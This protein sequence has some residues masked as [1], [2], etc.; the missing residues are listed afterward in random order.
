MKRTKGTA[1]GSSFFV[2]GCFCF[3]EGRYKER[4]A[5]VVFL[6]HCSVPCAL[7]LECG[8]VMGQACSHDRNCLFGVRN[9]AFGGVGEVLC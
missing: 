4:Y 9:G 5:A 2:S 8:G 1:S 7:I 6:R 3:T